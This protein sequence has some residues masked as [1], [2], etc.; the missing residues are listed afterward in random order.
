MTPD[1][2]LQ[3]Q[4]ENAVRVVSQKRATTTAEE[5]SR[6]ACAKTP[7]RTER[8]GRGSKEKRTGDGR[9]SLLVYPLSLSLS[10]SLSLPG[11]SPPPL[12][13]SVFLGIFLFVA[14][15]LISFVENFRHFSKK[16]GKKSTLSQIHCFKF[17]DRQK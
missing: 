1:Q 3:I 17:L 6:K 9:A 7:S 11:S 10:L 13:V 5:T 15:A 2:K 12:P 8:A 14:Q 16:I 4:N